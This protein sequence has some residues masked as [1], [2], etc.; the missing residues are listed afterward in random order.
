MAS[1][2]VASSSQSEITI[3]LDNL[4]NAGIAEKTLKTYKSRLTNMQKKCG[5]C[6]L[7]WIMQHP[8]ETID[9]LT[10]DKDNEV[11]GTLA[12]SSVA[13]C[14][15]FAVHPE[16]IQEWN[17]PFNIWQETLKHYRK[18]EDDKYKE[19]KM[20]EKQ[21]EKAVKFEDVVA[22]FE[23]LQKSNGIRNRL[24]DHME[25]ILFAMLIHSKP[26]RADL[27]NIQIVEKKESVTE[28]N[29]LILSEDSTNAT[30]TISA[31]KT[32][33]AHGPIV[34]ELSEELTTILKESKQQFPRDYLIISAR[35]NGPYTENNSY[36]HF[37]SRTFAKHFGK[38]TGISLWRSIYINANIDFNNMS[39]KE[40]EDN[41]KLIGH[42]VPIMMKT[43]RKVSKQ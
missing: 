14:K 18:I 1:F 33:K 40:I 27:G 6:T 17:I 12:A 5:N 25:Y 34:E 4:T 28:P 35:N 43:Y 9:K 32:A 19:S 24:P 21:E 20:T 26:K 8:K 15:L 38:A 39:Y 2:P 3:S 30:L 10:G 11:V 36:S 31:Y 29:Y 22:K 42:T 13:V 7:D 23:E 41:A 37:V 16:A